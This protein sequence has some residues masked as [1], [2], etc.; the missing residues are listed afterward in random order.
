MRSAEIKSPLTKGKVQKIADFKTSVITRSYQSE[1]GISV[2]D[3]FCDYKKIDLYQCQESGY[4]FYYPFDVAGNENFY[5][6]LAKFDWYYNSWKWEHEQSLKY[7]YHSNSILEIG[8]GSGGFIKNLKHRFPQKMIT[9][10]EITVNSETEKFILNETI[11]EH[12]SRSEEKYDLVCSY[13][14]LEHISDVHSFL[15]SSIDALRIGGH[16]ILSVP[17]NDGLLLKKKGSSLLNL[18]PHH[19]G[20]WNKRSLQFLTKIFP[21]NLIEEYYEPIQD[22]HFEWFKNIIMQQIRKYNIPLS[23]RLSGNNR[24]MRII[25][26]ALR[27]L[28]RGHTIMFVYQKK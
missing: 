3:T 8:C 23:F 10:L 6:K 27:P 25:A 2:G 14:V 9:G 7:I 12:V 26:F 22:Y 20:L 4:E 1:L 5:K 19:M 28:F 21:L 13:Q 18:P 15:Q 24:F 16:L 11:Q 17:N